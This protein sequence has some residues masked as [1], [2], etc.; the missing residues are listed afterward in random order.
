MSSRFSSVSSLLSTNLGSV[1]LWDLSP[2]VGT[3]FENEAILCTESAPPPPPLF[4]QDFFAPSPGGLE[5]SCQEVQWHQG[6][7]Q[8]KWDNNTGSRKVEVI[9]RSNLPCSF[10][11]NTNVYF[12]LQMYVQKKTQTQS[13]K[14]LIAYYKYAEINHSRSDWF[15]L[16]CQC[17]RAWSK[18]RTWKEGSF[19]KI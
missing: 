11:N 18:I 15:V 7:C 17:L 9:R 6:S 4:G 12:M 16:D 5:A 2:I 3:T 10:Q 8:Q 19:S 14:K 1:K 13:Q